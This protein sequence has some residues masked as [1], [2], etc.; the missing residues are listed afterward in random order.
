[1]S[2]HAQISTA[3][4]FVWIAICCHQQANN[5]RPER[6]GNYLFCEGTI[7]DTELVTHNLTLMTGLL[8]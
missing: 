5:K 8:L 4:L 7:T 3:F 1:M 6:P 2:H